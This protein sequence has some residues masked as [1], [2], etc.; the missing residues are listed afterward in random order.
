MLTCDAFGVMPPLARLT[1]TQAMDYFLA[2]YTAK[3]AGTERGIVEPQA[4]FSTCFGAPF[5][6]RHPKVYAELLGDLIVKHNVACWLVNT[7][8]TG[9]P[10]GRGERISL[11]KT[12]AL[13]AW[14]LAAHE[15]NVGFRHDNYFGLGVPT[16]VPGID[17]GLLS[18]EPGWG[19]PAGYAAQAKKLKVMFEEALRRVS[20]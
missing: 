1:H 20:G 7:G 5:M 10:Y 16:H 14:A 11:S 8:W 13:L 4:T 12:R 2:G 6:P 3:V 9:G 15:G 17:A 18:P 19:D